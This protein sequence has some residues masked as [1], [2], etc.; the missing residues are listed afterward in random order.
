MD[1]DT[2]IELFIKNYRYARKV[3]EEKCMPY[4]ESLFSSLAALLT[5]LA[6]KDITKQE[7]EE[8]A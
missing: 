6:I 8:N 3:V 4:D 2:I 5:L 7:E 1:K